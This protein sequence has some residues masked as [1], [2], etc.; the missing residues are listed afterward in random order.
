MVEIDTS[1]YVYNASKHVAV[2]GATTPLVPAID[3]TEWTPVLARTRIQPDTRHRIPVRVDADITY[4]RLDVFPDGGISRL[5][6]IGA[7]RGAARRALGIAWFDTLPPAQAR[8]VLAERCGVHGAV[9]ERFIAARPLAPETVDAAPPGL[10]ALL[11][12]D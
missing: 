3:S 6:V 12:G 11:A 5:R 9:A 8:Q 1:Y 10:R 7:V 2:F 4:V